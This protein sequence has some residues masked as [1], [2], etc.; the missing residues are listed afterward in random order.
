MSL[1]LDRQKARQTI[2]ASG[3][4]DGEFYRSTYPDMRS[5][6]VDPLTHYLTI[7]EAEGRSPNAVFLPHYY[8]WHAV[9]PVPPEGNAP[10]H[11]AE[12]GKRLGTKPHPAVDPSAYLAANPQLPDYAF[13]IDHMKHNNSRATAAVATTVRFP[14]EV[15][16]RYV[17]C[18]RSCAFQA[19]SMISCGTSGRCCFVHWPTLGVVR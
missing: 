19:M 1:E 14:R 16:R 17:L 15:N 6:A 2:L 8:R 7:G 11:Y 10:A 18:R 4:F 12:H 9:L 5:A 13:P 3:L